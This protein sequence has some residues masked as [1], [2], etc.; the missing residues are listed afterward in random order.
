[1]KITS[2]LELADKWEGI[3]TTPKESGLIDATGIVSPQSEDD[4]IERGR[5]LG[6]AEAAD[7]LQNLVQ[8]LG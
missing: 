8:L 2:L 4:L 7:Q 3:A 5:R 6:Y 1:M